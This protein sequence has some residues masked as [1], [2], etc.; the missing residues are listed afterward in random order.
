MSSELYDNANDL[1]SKVKNDKSVSAGVTIGVSPTGSPYTVNV[2]PSGSRAASLLDKL[3]KYNQKVLKHNA[4]VAQ[5]SIVYTE[6]V[7]P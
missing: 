2:G 5:Y 1:L 4:S 7:L 6:H 3:D